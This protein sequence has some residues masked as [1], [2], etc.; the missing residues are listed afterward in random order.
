MLTTRSSNED[1]LLGP[2]K[3]TKIRK[4][5]KKLKLTQ[6]RGRY[7]LSVNRKLLG[8]KPGPKRGSTR[9]RRAALQRENPKA[10]TE[11]LR[12]SFE[13]KKERPWSL[14][15]TRL[16]QLTVYRRIRKFLW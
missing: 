4:G 9:R 16:S 8:K 5:I 13:A 3:A 7:V 15:T 14:P 1:I 10:G 6:F 12:S 2:Q 11:I